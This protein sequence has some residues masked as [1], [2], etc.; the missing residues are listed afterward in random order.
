MLQPIATILAAEATDQLD[1]PVSMDGMQPLQAFD[2]GARAAIQVVE[3]IAR[4]KES[5]LTGA[6]TQQALALVNWE[7]RA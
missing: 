7:N 4:A 1:T 3:L 6:Q 5:G 2:N